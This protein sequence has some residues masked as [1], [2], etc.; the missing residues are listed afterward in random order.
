MGI[1]PF[2]GKGP[3]TLLWAVLLAASEKIT[4][5]VIHYRI[6]YCVFNLY[7]VGTLPRKLLNLRDFKTEGTN[8]SKCEICK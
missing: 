7:A 2:Y 4:M 6:H 1:Q 3:H 8:N 5:S